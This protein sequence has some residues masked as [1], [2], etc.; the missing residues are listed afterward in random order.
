MTPAFTL[1]GTM[2]AK[3][4]HHVIGNFGVNSGCKQ[5]FMGNYTPFLKHP[6]MNTVTP[7]FNNTPNTLANSASH[8]PKEMSKIKRNVG[9]DII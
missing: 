1:E 3:I 2:I 9:N 6:R 5:D 8:F 4:Y 7:L